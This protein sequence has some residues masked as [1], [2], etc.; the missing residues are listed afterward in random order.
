[1][2]M[3]SCLLLT[4]DN[5]KE[6]VLLCPAVRAFLVTVLQEGVAL[7]AEFHFF[8][9]LLP[10]LRLWPVDFWQVAA[11]LPLPILPFSFS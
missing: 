6:L 8:F 9:V 4:C 11:A 1:M 10:V 7:G 2:L 3:T 5:L